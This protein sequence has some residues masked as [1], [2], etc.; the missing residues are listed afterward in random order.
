MGAALRIA[1][2]DLRL[3]VRDRSVLILGI[4]A[5]LVLSY[6]FYLVFGPAATGQGLSLE[7]GMVDDDRSEIS[8]AF[9][10][11]LEGAAAEG[12]LE[13]TTFDESAGA[14]SALDEGE[15]DAYFHLPSGLGDS[16]F[17]NQAATID[18]VG[19]VDSP[20][21]TQI[22]AS[23]AEQFA[24]G[25]ASS[26]TAVATAA[27]VSG[28]TVTPEFIGS[29]S[30]DPASAAMSFSFIDE[31]AA[32][33]QLD[34]S[35]FFAAGMAVFFLFFTVQFGVT[36]LLEEERQGT[37]ARLMAAPIARV[38]VIAG[39]AILAFILGVVSM[40]V[41]VVATTLLMEADWGAPLGVAV[42]VVAGVLSAVGIMGLVASV[43]KTP[44]GAGN[45]GAIIA[46]VLGMLGGTF[47]PIASSGG[48]LANLTYLTPH[49]W[50]ML[51]LAELGS[52]APWTAAL[53]AAG[54]IMVFALVTGG[55]SYI[56]L[57][58]RLAQ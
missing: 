41:L 45:L 32:T 28:Q 54:A 7:Y 26:Q 49:A 24:S 48:I 1:A 19:D 29:L 40:A 27:A 34:A 50:F 57:R 14:A 31:T 11:V 10:A 18:V 12:V 9:T 56:L 44:E 42:L 33:K 47:F 13:L 5:P 20:T 25:V 58:R 4:I 46:V 30:Q 22:A 39:K 15:I 35:T 8:T 53:P 17:A 55:L 52:D 2:K 3:R 38:S 51:G 16:V 37:L 6:I 23:F 43:A 36:G 21:S